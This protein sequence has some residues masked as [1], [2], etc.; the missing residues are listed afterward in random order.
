MKLC[1][2]EANW[3]VGMY[4]LIDFS[5]RNWKKHDF[6]NSLMWLSKDN[7]ES[8]MTPRLRN[9][10]LGGIAVTS[11]SLRGA[12]EL[13]SC[14]REKGINIVLL[15]FSLSWF[16]FMKELMREKALQILRRAVASLLIASGS[17]SKLT[18]NWVSSAYRWLEMPMPL[19]IGGNRDN[20]WFR[21]LICHASQVC[22]Q[23]WFTTGIKIKK[24]VWVV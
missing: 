18:Q 14:L 11:S 12:Y 9:F 16:F 5:R 6:L 10:I 3:P 15:P 21:G 20:M 19:S 7:L 8:I 17:S 24:I 22:C 2:R 4:S 23:L 1:I 13:A